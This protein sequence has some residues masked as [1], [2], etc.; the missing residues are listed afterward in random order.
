M[1][2]WQDWSYMLYRCSPLGF[3]RVF[4][5]RTINIPGRN[6]R[7]SFTLQCF[8]P[9]V[10]KA[11]L[12]ERLGWVLSTHAYTLGRSQAAASLRYAVDKD[13]QHSSVAAFLPPQV[14]E[15]TLEAQPRPLAGLHLVRSRG[16]LESQKNNNENES[17]Y[18]RG[19]RKGKHLQ[20]GRE[21]CKWVS[22]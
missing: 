11:L 14:T 16:L 8:V 12:A 17:R 9:R 5:L 18:R 2:S 20:T 3:A 13:Y 4:L 15:F 19:P 1:L 21:L 10:F 6:K 22:H 7:L